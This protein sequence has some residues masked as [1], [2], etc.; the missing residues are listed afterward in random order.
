M[1]P[2]LYKLKNYPFGLKLYS[3]LIIT[4]S[5]LGDEVLTKNEENKN[6]K[7]NI[8]NNNFYQYNF[9]NSNF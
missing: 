4:Y 6:K 3:K 8:I 5:Y 1:A 9:E 2:F 7:E